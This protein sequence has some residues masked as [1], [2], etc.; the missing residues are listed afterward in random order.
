MKGLPQ[1]VR[2]WAQIKK[3]DYCWLWAGPTDKDGYGI[4]SSTLHGTRYKKAHRFSLSMHLGVPL[5]PRL[6]VLHACD[7]PRCINPAHLSLGTSSQNMQD[8]V[9]KGR[10]T[11]KWDELHPHVELT[12]TDK[13]K[14]RLD[15]R[16]YSAIAADFNVDVARIKSIKLTSHPFPESLSNAVAMDECQVKGCSENSAVLGLCNLH[17]EH[18]V[19]FGSPVM[20][21]RHVGMFIGRSA[22]ERFWVQVQKQDGCWRWLGAKDKDGYGRFRGEIGG[23]VYQRAHR[24]SYALNT[25]EIVRPESIVMHS[26]DNPECTNPDHLSVGTPKQNME[27]KAHKGRSNIA[28]GERSSRAKLNEA[29]VRE[30]LS[31]TRPYSAIADDYG[32]SPSTI[33]S[34]KQRISWASVQMEVSRGKKIGVRGEKQWSAKLTADDVREIRSSPLSGKELAAK[35]GVTPAGISNIRNRRVWK[36]ID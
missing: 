7:N 5:D 17:W 4:F 11:R 30:I 2:F 29:Q 1:E 27:D 34:I 28:I 32:V 24:F 21:R 3:T 8:R 10:A 6:L 23:V 16:P 20:T 36:H 35:F 15:P 33:G 26:C 18:T 14:I 31:D 22:Q 13:S 19:S 12:L 9:L 25:G